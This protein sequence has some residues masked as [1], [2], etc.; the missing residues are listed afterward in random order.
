MERFEK[1]C[2][3]LINARIDQLKDDISR[4]LVQNFEEYKSLA[5]RIQ[6]LNEALFALEDAIKKLID[7]KN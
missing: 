4:G 3:I 7:N 2:R 5:G 1:E 6:G